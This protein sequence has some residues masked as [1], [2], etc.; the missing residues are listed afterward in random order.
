MPIYDYSCRACGNQFEALVRR[1]T[2]PVCPKCQGSDL[3]RHFSPPAVSSETTRGL[4]MR[5]ANK[6]DAKQAAENNYTQREY[7]KNHD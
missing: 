2:V 7:E 5:A 4:A 3:E 6:R 1:E